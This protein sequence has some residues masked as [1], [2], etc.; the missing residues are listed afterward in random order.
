MLPI[1]AARSAEVGYGFRASAVD[2]YDAV[3]LVGISI[4]FGQCISRVGI[5][6]AVLDDTVIIDD[7]VES[8]PEHDA[9]FVGG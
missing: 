1:P 3:W 5:L 6:A 7:V 4:Q 8:R 9:R 2:E